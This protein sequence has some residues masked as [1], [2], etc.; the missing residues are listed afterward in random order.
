LLSSCG[1]VFPVQAPPP[2]KKTVKLP[3]IAS[4]LNVSINLEVNNIQV[5][6]KMKV[7][8]KVKVKL[9]RHTTF[10]VK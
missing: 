9:D 1:P 3:Q 7:K 4:A 10:E 5:K 8:V 6:M 2:K